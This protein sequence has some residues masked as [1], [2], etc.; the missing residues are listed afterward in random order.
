MNDTHPREPDLT[1][2]P[3][4]PDTIPNQFPPRDLNPRFIP[5]RGETFREAARRKFFE[6]LRWLNYGPDIFFAKIDVRVDAHELARVTRDII[7]LLADINADPREFNE[8]HVYRKNVRRKLRESTARLTE[9]TNLV[10]GN[11]L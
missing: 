1:W 7:A 8:L 6:W 5:E 9:L 3:T 4:W 11:I 2:L 10:K